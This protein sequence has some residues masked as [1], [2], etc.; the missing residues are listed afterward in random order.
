[1]DELIRHHSGD[2]TIPARLM[3]DNTTMYA[4]NSQN[5]VFMLSSNILLLFKS[6][7]MDNGLE[8]IQWAYNIP[9]FGKL[10]SMSRTELLQLLPPELHHKHVYHVS[11]DGKINLART[12][13][14]TYLH[15]ESVR[16]TRD[17]RESY[18]LA[19]KDPVWNPPS[20]TIPTHISNV[21]A[22]H[23]RGDKWRNT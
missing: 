23:P 10:R 1:M 3:Y 9:P 5:R 21:L 11:H 22:Q 13:L 2:T 17:A 8:N 12:L 4:V 7:V 20:H 14:G 18:T 16:F 15:Y 6:T 19:W